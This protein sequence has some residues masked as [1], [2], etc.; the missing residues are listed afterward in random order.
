[1]RHEEYSWRKAIRNLNFDNNAVHLL[2]RMT[3]RENETL[4]RFGK[5]LQ[6]RIIVCSRRFE[7]AMHKS[8]NQLFP[9]KWWTRGWMHSFLAGEIRGSQSSSEYAR[10]ITWQRKVSRPARANTPRWPC[11]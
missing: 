6:E 5:E 9:V 7:A 8:P 4:S 10:D 1:M 3:S 11:A 2:V